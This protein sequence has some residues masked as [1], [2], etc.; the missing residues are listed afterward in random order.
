MRRIAAFLR[1]R[2]YAFALLLCVVLV[3]LNVVVSPTF[4]SPERW[5]TTLGTLAP[6]VLVGFAST[7]SV[8]SGG[9]D[10]S[11]GPLATLT[12]IVF[13]TVLLPS[14]LGEPYI[15]IPLLL[16]LAAGVGAVNGLLVAVVRLHPVVA[17]TG[18]LFLLVGLT[19]TISR[20]SVQAPA[21][22]TAPL[23]R[24]V[25]FLPGAVFTIGG[26][27]LIWFLLRRSAYVR[28]LLATGESDVSAYGSG[29]DVTRVRVIAYA[30]GGLFAGIGGIALVALLQSAEPSLATTYTLLGLA[31]VVIGGTSLGGGRGGLVGTFFGA[32]AIYLLN[33]L[34]TAAGVQTNLI[35]F[36]YG[37][38]LIAGLLLGATLLNP[39]EARRIR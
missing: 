33:Q 37:L 10:V 36:T 16:V 4:A 22:W 18:M 30:L 32:T 1:R 24:S 19:L 29:V 27:A 2:P 39:R 21:N 8:L 35:Q 31:A 17:T 5:A 20:T 3:V 13:V 14:G 25:W 6:F 12:S 34:L 38:V 7:P 28:N 15:A 9:V 11:V 26:A 23:A